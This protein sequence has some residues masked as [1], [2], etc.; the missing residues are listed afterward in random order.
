MVRNGFRFPDGDGFVIEVTE[1]GP[2]CV[3]LSDRGH[4]VRHINDDRDTDALFRP[5]ELAALDRILTE[6]RVNREVAVFSVDTAVADVGPA[7]IRLGQALSRISELVCSTTRRALPRA[8]PGADREV[9]DTLPAALRSVICVS[10]RSPLGLAGV[11]G[12]VTLA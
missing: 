9:G 12:A 1:I 5:E 6:V 10:A 8:T 3:R 11:P 4:T 2:D 7:G